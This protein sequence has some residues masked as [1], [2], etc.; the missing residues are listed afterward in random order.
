MRQKLLHAG[1]KQLSYEIR[2]IVWFAEKVKQSGLDICWENIWDPIAKGETIPA[3]VKEIIAEALQDDK[4]FGYVHSKGLLS[5]REYIASKNDII[6]P[7]D[8]IFFNGLW[9]AINKIYGYLS[10]VWWDIWKDGL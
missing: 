2:E 9:E 5:T 7:E 8:I 1:Y 6:G 3:W 10:R 4:V